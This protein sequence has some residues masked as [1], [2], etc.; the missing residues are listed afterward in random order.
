MA[1]L[2]ELG[3]QWSVKTTLLPECMRGLMVPCVISRKGLSCYVADIIWLPYILDKLVW[4]H[5]LSP[6]EVAAVLFSIK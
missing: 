4:K 6:E 2:P 3:S 5:H 1:V